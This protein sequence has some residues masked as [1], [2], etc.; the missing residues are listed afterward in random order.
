[1]ILLVNLKF[2][3]CGTTIY[4][5]NLYNS[6]Q[7]NGSRKNVFHKCS[8]LQDSFINDCVTVKEVTDAIMGQK[9][10]KAQMDLRWRPLYTVELRYGFI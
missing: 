5:Q 1:V 8:L 7:D 9:K 10:S 3:I 4:F 6:I 2:V